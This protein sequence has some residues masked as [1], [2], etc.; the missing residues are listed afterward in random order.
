MLYCTKLWMKQ[1]HVK[2][3]TFEK[4]K[5]FDHELL[6]SQFCKP[7]SGISKA[8]SNITACGEV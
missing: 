3:S 8:S 2:P 5:M 7:V 6:Q 4:Y 1:L